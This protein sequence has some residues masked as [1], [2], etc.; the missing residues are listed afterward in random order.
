MKHR[1]FISLSVLVLCG[2][3]VSS[4]LA[5]G[6]GKGHQKGK[7]TAVAGK[8]STNAR[9]V[10]SSQDRSIVSGWFREHGASGLPPGL[11]KRDRLPP[12]L[13]RQLRERGSLPPGLQ[14]KLQPLPIELER[15]LPPLPEGYRRS[16][17][18]AHV[19]ITNSHGTFVFDVMRDVVPY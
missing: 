15:R 17:I 12:G 9:V 14:K 3:I 10:F 2:G 19:V 6:K 18:G 7:E 16:V 13:E 4:A 1:W 11:A 8:S 5:Q